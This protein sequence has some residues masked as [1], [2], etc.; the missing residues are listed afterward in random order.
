MHILNQTRSTLLI[1]Q[2]QI[3]DT[4]L[5]RLRGLLGSKPLNEGEGLVL[6]GE[7]SIHTF[8]MDFPIDVV[9]VNKNYEIIRVQENMVPYRL[10][11]LVFGSAYVLEM[12][13]ETIARTNTKVGDL[14]K[15]ES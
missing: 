3:A 5:L 9:Y 1:S 10:G 7:K 8:F 15:F 2:V 11:P 12:P 14:L 4:F 13:V 6:V